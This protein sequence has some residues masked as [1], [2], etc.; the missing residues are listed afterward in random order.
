[1]LPLFDFY[2][3]NAMVEEFIVKS[4]G[5]VCLL[6]DN[7]DLIE[8]PAITA[9]ISAFLTIKLTR[10]DDN[11]VVLI[12]HDIDFYEEFKIDGPLSYDSPLRYVKAVYN[13]LRDSVDTG[14]RLEIRSEIPVG[15][16][17]SSSA[18]LCIA[19]IYAFN[20]AY[21]IK[22]TKAEVAEL[23]YIVEHDDLQVECGR[24]DQYAIAFRGINY[25]N[26]SSRASIE[27]LGID[28]LPIVVADSREQHNTKEVQIWLRDRI[29]KKEKL[30]INSL[31]RVVGI[32]EE[33]KR[34]LM[35]KD[36]KKL[37]FLMDRQ[38]EEEKLMGT[39]TDK[40]EFLCRKAREA[41]ALGAKQMGAGGGGC[42]I[43][44]CPIHTIEIVRKALQ[45]SGVP[46]WAFKTV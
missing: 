21:K 16:G 32:V 7:T 3:V 39:S 20:R 12:G 14:F 34:A 2:M 23:A 38:Q 27:K 29:H 8:K 40:L 28:Y 1:M 19:S 6:G 11:R 4:P 18:A 9:A 42:I 35:G 26:T 31:N 5:R 43:A 45:A 10:R 37:G 44:L 25:I 36:F 13:R 46:A 30:L 17:L 15:A 41:G 22:M 24:M 33:G